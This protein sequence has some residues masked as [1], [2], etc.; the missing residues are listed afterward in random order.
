M[1]CRAD[2]PERNRDARR[3]KEILKSRTQED[4]MNQEQFEAA[5]RHAAEEAVGDVLDSAVFDHGRGIVTIN[6]RDDVY[7]GQPKVLE[8]NRLQPLKQKLAEWANEQLST[9]GIGYE[10]WNKDAADLVDRLVLPTGIGAFFDEHDPSPDGNR[11]LLPEN[12]LIKAQADGVVRIELA[13]INE[14]LIRYLAKHPERMHELDPR[15]FEELVAEL[16]RNFGY[17]AILTPRSKD[18]G[19]DIRASYKEPV[20]TILTLVE[21]KKYSPKH[22]VGVEIVR[23]LRG[24]ADLERATFAMIATTSR[25]TSGAREFV[26]R[27]QHQ[28]SLKDGEDLATWLRNYKAPRAT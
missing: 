7:Q 15:K 18:G 13:Q 19:F 28:L 5:F 3:M 2:G 6:N 9:D 10:F 20:G 24:V 12:D 25:F 4:R 23:G 22:P 26:A 16:L 21:C 17:D 8:F 14:E 1:R 27:A 11:N